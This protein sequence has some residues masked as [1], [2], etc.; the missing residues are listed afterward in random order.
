MSIARRGHISVSQQVEEIANLRL[1]PVDCIICCASWE[2]R[3]TSLVRNQNVKAKVGILILFKNKGESGR[4][5]KHEAEL[6]N[7]M[8]AHCEDKDIRRCEI[9]SLDTAGTFDTLRAMLGD[10]V[11]DANRPMNMLIDF[12]C[13]PKLYFLFTLS[14]MLRFGFARRIQAYYCEADYEMGNRKT[15]AISAVDELTVE[16][17]PHYNYTD[18]GWSPVVVPFLD[19]QFNPEGLRQVFASL[20]FEGGTSHQLVAQYDPD[21]LQPILASPG[22]SEEYTDLAVMEN[23]KLLAS[24]GLSDRRILKFQAGDVSG[25]F[26][27][28]ST[29]ATAKEA[30]RDVVYLCFGTKTHALGLGLS[31]LVLEYP[32][33]VCRVPKKFLERDSKPRN[34]AWCYTIEDTTALP[35]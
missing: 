24:F 11:K 3:S 6:L 23:K 35:R 26:S 19:G 13:F 2:S 4:S 15:H 31:A 29:A 18:G 30:P 28:V 25:L 1:S 22:F 7:W 27:A 21:D 34:R 32:T 12:T 16:F 10:L 9:D 17:I 14:V 33:V 20:G 8:A 5:A